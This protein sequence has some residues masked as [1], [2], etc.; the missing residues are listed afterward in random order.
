M[1]RDN[2]VDASRRFEQRSTTPAKHRALN[3]LDKLA[4]VT[5]TSLAD[6]AILARKL[7]EAA[8]RLNPKAPKKGAHAIISEA[9][10]ENGFESGAKKTGRLFVFEGKDVPDVL[11]SS[12]PTWANLVDKAARLIAAAAGYHPAQVDHEYRHQVSR[13][14][15][16][17]SFLPSL[18]EATSTP[19]ASRELLERLS[20]KFVQRLQASTR[21]FELWSVLEHAPFAVER[22]R[23]ADPQPTGVVP[24][25][26]K[27]AAQIEANMRWRDDRQPYFVPMAQEAYH[28]TSW[29]N[30][31]L[32][33]G[34]YARPVRVRTFI[35]PKHVAEAFLDPEQ[36][37][38]EAWEK[39]DKWQTDGKEYDYDDDFP[40]HDYVPDLGHGAKWE[41]YKA[42]YFV[43][44]S[45]SKSN[46]I[47][48]NV[49]VHVDHDFV[50]YYAAPPLRNILEIGSFIFDQHMSDLEFK[51]DVVSFNSR[52]AYITPTSMHDFLDRE[53]RTCSPVRLMQSDS[54][55]Q[56]QFVFDYPYELFEK[57][58]FTF[59]DDDED[60]LALIYGTNDFEFIPNFPVDASIN[61]PVRKGSLAD[62]LLNNATL[63]PEE[64]LI[65]MIE[66]D[67]KTRADA[68]LGYHH[69]L[70]RY[71]QEIVDKV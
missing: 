71:Y 56:N 32:K 40:E 34:A 42:L 3:A 45:I 13:L 12:G 64:Q 10:A 37:G 29:S 22:V 62:A 17:T 53:Y 26:S 49:S 51:D 60:A 59:S 11:E 18:P 46:N 70:I 67:A 21:L 61:T 2:V 30:V 28:D 24:A 31:F 35:P 39:F 4:G 47:L 57:G 43:Y 20:D 19:T 50:C 55:S 33:I 65:A 9:W 1:T 52:R 54:S 44:L 16:G 41:T 48:P 15:R 25:A 7:G 5:R 68:G 38:D 14:L 63:P 8:V 27:L 66:R 23:A 6:R 36:W 58:E 69:A